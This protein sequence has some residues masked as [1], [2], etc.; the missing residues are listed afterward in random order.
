MTIRRRTRIDKGDKF[1]EGSRKL[2]IALQKRGWSMQQARAELKLAEGVLN[3]IL[4]G[5]RRAGFRLAMLFEKKFQIPLT[6]WSQ[7][8]KKDFALPEF[9]GAA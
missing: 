1:S 6:D 2:W 7:S 9:L 3:R 4:Y 5:D 8:A